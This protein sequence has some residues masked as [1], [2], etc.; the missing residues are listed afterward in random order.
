MN[1]EEQIS[2]GDYSVTITIPSVKKVWYKGQYHYYGK[3][4]QESQYDMLEKI[5]QK[6]NTFPQIK[7]VYETHEDQRLHAHMW[8]LNE[9]E[10]IVKDFRHKIYSDH[11]INIRPGSYLKISDIQR[12][13]VSINYFNEYM[14]KHQ[15]NIKYFMSSDEA[16][17]RKCVIDDDTF[18]LYIESNIPAEYVNSLVK[19]QE[20]E[21]LPDTYPFGKSNKFIVE[22]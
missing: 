3:L 1:L 17:R 22:I 6:Y 16:F 19:G 9:Y 18:H 13:L 15:A 20:T 8:I 4:T 2:R 12:T 7:W 11:A 5:L 14:Q 10:E 21:Y